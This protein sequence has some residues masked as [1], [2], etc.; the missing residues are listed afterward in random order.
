VRVGINA[1]PLFQRVPTGAGVYALAL[2]HAL[3]N[4]G[5]DDDVI[6]FHAAH[7]LVPAEVAALGME[8]A[9][10][11][12]ERDELYRSWADARRPAPQVVCGPL[13]LVHAP[14]PML[15]PSGGA[16]LVAT[17]HDLAPLRFPDRYPRATRLTLKRSLRLATKEADRIVCPSHSTADELVEL[18]DVRRDQV[19]VVPH[20]VAIPELDADAARRFVRQRGIRE[21]YVL[22]IGTQEQRKNVPAVID[23]FAQVAKRDRKI[24]LVLHGPQGWLGSGVAESIRRRKLESRIMVSEGS[25]ERPE[26]ASLY[27]RASVFLF[28]S[29][30]EGFGLPV[31]EAM[32]CGVPVIAS[33]R[34][35]VPES[36]GDAAVLVDPDD[37]DEL[38][39]QLEA[40]LGDPEARAAL[41]ERGRAR[42]AAFTWETT[43]RRTWDVYDELTGS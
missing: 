13:D 30:Y 23:A 11:S 24:A 28:P 26:L 27:S 35:A 33:N 36:A 42:A 18:L 5:H 32:A 8:R 14:S 41:I 20:G 25:L 39:R 21:P 38:G 37:H 9:A 2:C 12:L 10:F 40:L 22:W 3:T 19:R 29:L 34:S 7:A 15:P 17:V 6:L 16:P 43:A 1:E 31:L 4:L